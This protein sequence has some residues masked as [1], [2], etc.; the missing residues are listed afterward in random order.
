MEL[1]TQYHAL[2]DQELVKLAINEDTAAFEQLFNRYRKELFQR[3]MQR[4]GNNRSDSND[5]FQDT[6]VK[7]YLNLHKYKP[8]FSFGQWVHTIARNTFIDYTR[9]QNDNIMSIDQDNGSGPWLNPPANTANPEEE[10][11]RHQTGKELDRV[12]AQMPEHYRIMITMRFI[13]EYTYDEIAEKLNMPLGT[14]KT[15]IHRA[16]EKFYQLISRND[17]IL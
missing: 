2:S 13:Q 11:M 4:T 8:T 15:Q 9:K 5:I 3:S 6:F 17:N 7:I 1:K 10:M 14:V 16:R 12:M